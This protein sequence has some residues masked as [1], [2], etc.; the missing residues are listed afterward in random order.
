MRHNA[1]DNINKSWL[2]HFLGGVGSKVVIIG[3]LVWGVIRIIKSAYR[4]ES[5]IDIIGATALSVGLA[6]LL[7]LFIKIYNP[8]K[9]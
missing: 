1:Q 4:G 7:Y 2:D 3:L 6:I 8:R 5:V 9:R